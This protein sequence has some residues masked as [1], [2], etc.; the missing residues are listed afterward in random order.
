MVFGC[1]LDPER[2]LR[3]EASGHR[4]NRATGQ[5]GSCPTYNLSCSHG[6]SRENADGMFS[7]NLWVDTGRQTADDSQ[8]GMSQSRTAE[9]EKKE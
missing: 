7:C 2:R 9:R 3:L 4:I 8:P 6:H 5:R 1:G